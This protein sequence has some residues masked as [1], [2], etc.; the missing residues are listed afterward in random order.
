MSDVV[1]S[2]KHDRKRRPLTRRDWFTVVRVLGYAHPYR[3]RIIVALVIGLVASLFT[4]LN[5]MALIPVLD[6]MIESKGEE[7]L[8]KIEAQISKYQ[9]ELGSQDTLS[10]KVQPYLDLQRNRLRLAWTRWVL[11]H[12]ETA[13]SWMA[14]VLVLAQI[15]KSVLEFNSKYRLQKSFYLSLVRLRTHLYTRCV[16]LDLPS[17]D[18]IT[19]GNLLARL[20]ND[21]RAVKQVFTSAVGDV[22]LQPFTALFL[23]VSLLILNW[24]LTLIVMV[25][26]PVIVLP[27][28]YVGKRLRTMGKKDEEEDAKLLDYTQ[29]TLQG[30]MIVKAFNGEEREVEKFDTLSTEMAK[31]QIRREKFRLYGEPFVEITASIAMAAVLCVGGYFILKADDASMRA[32]EFLIYLVIL[33]RFYPP[34]KSVSNMFIKLQ[35]ALASADRIFEII[36]TPADIREKPGAVAIRPIQEQIEFRD[37][38]FSYAPGKPSVLNN[39]SLTIPKGKRIALVGKSGAGKSTVSKLL[40]RLYNLNSGAILIDDIDIS[41]GTLASLRGQLAMVSQDTILFN[42]TVANNIRY[43]KPGATLDEVMEAAKSAYAH[44]FIERLPHGYETVV[45]ERGNQL[46]GGQRQRLAIARALLA[47]TPILILDEATSA[48]DPESEAIVQRAIEKLMEHRTSI[49]IAHRLSTIRKA[50]EIIVMHEGRIAERGTH[51]EL[52]AQEGRYYD[53]LQQH[54]FEE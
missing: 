19:S 10:E 41:E 50:D 11:D 22:M 28:S 45:G 49:V 25:G 12:P 36:D 4:S 5:L 46:S 54:E 52:V 14:A 53:L 6:V 18:K 35:K 30:L 8:V 17:F 33:S 20:N 51:S 26:M 3:K 21:M 48:L 13:I 47:D 23:F 1:K 40:P 32:T 43:A 37:V 42:D 16:A 15:L 44:E 29:E 27:I 31:R 38:T 34:I 2:P 7:S 9:K 24:Q 39:F